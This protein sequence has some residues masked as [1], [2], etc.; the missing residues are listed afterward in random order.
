MSP[1]MLAWLKTKPESIQKLAAEF[2]IGCVLFHPKTNARIYLVG[3]N[4]Q[5]ML[6]V[7]DLDPIRD[8]E[9]AQATKYY[10]CAAH[11]RGT[12]ILSRQLEDAPRH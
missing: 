10:V 3:Y 9:A 2:P 8:W 1:D 11:F 6:I 12:V 5:D 7:S 4:E